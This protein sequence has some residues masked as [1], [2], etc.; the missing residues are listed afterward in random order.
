MLRSLTTL[1]LLFT[2]ALGSTAHAEWNRKISDVRIVHPPG[3]PPGTWRVDV[4]VGIEVGQAAPSPAVLDLDLHLYLNDVGIGTIPVPLG[5]LNGASCFSSG[6]CQPGQCGGTLNG[7]LILGE[8][9]MFSTGVGP[10][11]VCGCLT[12]AGTFGFGPYPDLRISDQIRVELVPSGTALAE[13]HLVDDVIVVPVTDNIVGEAF[14]GGD[15]SLPTP[16]PCANS[17]ASGHGCANSANPSGALLVATGW[18]ELDSVTG[19]DGVTLR[20]SGMPA[21]VSAI[22]LKSDATNPTGSVFGDG[23]SCLTGSLIRLRTKINVGG[24]SQFPEPGD[25]SV[26]VRG[27]TPPG[28]GL[29]GHYAVY[30]RNAAGAFCPPA[31][32]NI[33]NAVSIVW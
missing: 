3:T 6:A 16:C 5:Y 33:S 29:V 24:A 8:C 27:A 26:S 2:V 18:T 15:G 13:F 14:C 31:T 7:Q 22:Y 12:A 9:G 20:G 4:N 10:L 28:S 19:V 30:Y 23:V 1:A 11:P 17:G 21:T 25:P 32:H